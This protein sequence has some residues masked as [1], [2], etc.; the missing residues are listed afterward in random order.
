MEVRGGM[1][2]AIGTPSAS[3]RGG[4]LIRAAIEF[5]YLTLDF[6]KKKRY[7]LFVQ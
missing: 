7:L 2:C 4:N 5:P 1:E 3:L 6:L